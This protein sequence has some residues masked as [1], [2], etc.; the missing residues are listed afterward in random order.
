MRPVVLVQVGAGPGLV[1]HALE[2]CDATL[3]AAAAPDFPPF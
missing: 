2:V 1:A 3:R